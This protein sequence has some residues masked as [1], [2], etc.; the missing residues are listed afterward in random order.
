MRFPGNKPFLYP[1][2]RCSQ[3]RPLQAAHR[4]DR[5]GVCVLT[6]CTI[7]SALVHKLKT[8]RLPGPPPLVRYLVV[9]LA[10]F[11]CSGSVT[12]LVGLGL[13]LLF[14]LPVPPALFDFPCRGIL[15]LFLAADPFCWDWRGRW[16]FWRH[17]ALL[18]SA[19]WSRIIFLARTIRDRNSSFL[20]SS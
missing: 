17:S 7:S 11:L 4:L 1:L 12:W 19:G 2:R 13:L 20:L 18:S 5:F 10:A 15:R 8:N 6:G 9:S 16:S 14:L 3:Q